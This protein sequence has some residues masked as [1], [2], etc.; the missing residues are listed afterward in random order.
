[1]RVMPEIIKETA[2]K[3]RKNLTQAESYLWENIRKWKILWKQF[4]KQ[5]PIFVYEEDSWLPRYIIADFY[6][7]ENKLIIELDWSVHSNKEVLELDKHKEMLLKNI[8]YKVIRFTNDEVLN[9]LE[10]TFQTIKKQLE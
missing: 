1:M 5:K 10:E 3:L 2:R 7:S 8:W 4:Q 6:C 9:N